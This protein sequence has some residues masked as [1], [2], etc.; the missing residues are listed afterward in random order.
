MNEELYYVI[1]LKHT[2]RIDLYIAAWASAD[3]GY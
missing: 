3:Q 1:S 2:R